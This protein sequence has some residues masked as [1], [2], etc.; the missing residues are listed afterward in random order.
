[1]DIS[2]AGPSGVGLDPQNI[3]VSHV[4]LSGKRGFWK[5]ELGDL[6]GGFEGI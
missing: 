2:K 4:A 3:A 1:M 5:G 6:R